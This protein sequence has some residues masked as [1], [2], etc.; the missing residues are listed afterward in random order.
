MRSANRIN[1]GSVLGIGA[2]AIVLVI[3]VY[4]GYSLNNNR[5]YKGIS[6]GNIDVSGLT[7]AQAVEKVR[8]S[9]NNINKANLTL[10]Y[11]NKKWNIPYSQINA[12]FNIG[13]AVEKAYSVGRNGNL[14]QRL[15][16]IVSTR[17]GKK[18]DVAFGYDKQQLVNFIT[19][20]QNE[21]NIPKKN[22]SLVSKGGIVV[23]VPHASGIK[24][25]LDKAVSLADNH[26]TKLSTTDLELPVIEDKP[27]VLATQ[28]TGFTDELGAFTT[29]FNTSDSARTQNIKLACSRINGTILNPA[30]IFSMDAALK[31][32]TTANGYKIA[33]AYLDDQVIDEVGGGVCQ[34]TTTLYDAALLANLSIIERSQHSMMVDYVEPGFDATVS[35]KGVDFKFK[36]SYKSPLYLYSS[37][38]GNKITMKVF[39]K[40]EDPTQKV[41][42]ETEVTDILYVGPDQIIADPSL[43]QG[44]K[45][46][47][48]KGKN[49][50]RS[51]LYKLIYKNGTLVSRE[52]VSES[53]YQPRQG[54]I[55]VGS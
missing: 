15:S 25:D 27:T 32:R 48:V 18:F 47:E 34:V 53:L 22:A 7:R 28:L 31:N 43:P 49:G 5:I 40:K 37:V 19:G 14:L 24:L 54:K 12:R 55:R 44:T 8:S 11:S 4:F 10:K 35:D 29:T 50:Y 52:K 41:Q 46:V 2:L 30:Q 6:I 23:V 45:K 13:E 20:I 33:K 51:A 17:S 26:I 3:S 39:G 38:D 36:N 21:I 42:L 1:K 16:D 9:L